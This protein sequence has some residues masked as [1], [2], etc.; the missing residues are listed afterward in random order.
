MIAP[1]AFLYQDCSNDLAQPGEMAERAQ[2][3]KIIEWHLLLYN[4]KKMLLIMPST[5]LR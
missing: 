4:L 2:T 5:G 1:H 3:I